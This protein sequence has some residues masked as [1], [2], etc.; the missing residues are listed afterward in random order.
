M[1][2]LTSVKQLFSS[3]WTQS[4]QQNVAHVFFC[5]TGPTGISVSVVCFCLSSCL[6]VSPW[7]AQLLF[8]NFFLYKYLLMWHFILFLFVLYL[9]RS[10]FS[11]LP[12]FSARASICYGEDSRHLEEC[13]R[14]CT[15]GDTVIL[16]V[17]MTP[18]RSKWPWVVEVYV[19]L[20][21]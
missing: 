13:A 9:C 14:T 8:L 10:F 6:F 17:T 1:H 18:S 19:D 3:R 2:L 21:K 5:L 15:E 12:L 4:L 11:F 20:D 16:L 7:P